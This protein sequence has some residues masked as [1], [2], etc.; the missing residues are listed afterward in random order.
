M[1][2]S[3]GLAGFCG[4]MMSV[5]AVSR[6]CMGVMGSRIVIIFFV[7]LC[8]FAM[9]FRSLFVMPRSVVMMLA[10]RV[11]MRHRVILH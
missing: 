11:L 7:M 2:V 3:M 9:V 4:M 1:L 5:M 6:R 8:G 10:G